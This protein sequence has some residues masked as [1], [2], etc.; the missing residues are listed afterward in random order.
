MTTSS[1]A[2]GQGTIYTETIVYSAPNFLVNEAPYQI[3][4]VTLDS[5][6]RLTCRVAGARVGIG[7]RVTFQQFQNGTPF[8]KKS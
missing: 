1:E 8:F 2:L 4:I 6:S 5:G 7:D 3:A